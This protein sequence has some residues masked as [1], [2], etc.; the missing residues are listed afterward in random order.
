MRV[1]MR[2][3]AIALILFAAALSASA[4]F[5]SQEG[6]E[7]T[8]SITGHVTI[9]GKGMQ[10]VIVMLTRNDANAMRTMAGVFGQKSTVKA[11]TDE[12]G[13]YQ[14]SNIAAGRYSINP[15]APIFVI[16]S[17]PGA[18]W[19]PGKIVNIA[20]GETIEKMDFA[21]TRGGVITGRITDAQGR[22]VVGQIVT[23]TPAE[24]ANKKPQS[25]DPFM[26]TALGN[27]MYKTDDRGIYRIY[28]L[29]AGSYLVSVSPS[30][31]GG[32]QLNLKRSYH[33]Q[34]FHPGVTDKTKASIVEV[35]EGNEA[36][37]IDIKLG[38]PAQTYKASGRIVDAVT[39]KPIA[40]AVANYGVA[41]GEAKIVMPRGLGTLANSKGEFQINQI[42]QG[43][44]HAFVSFDEGSDSYSDSTPFEISNGDV[45]GIVIK[46]HRGLSVSGIVSIEGTTD[47]STLASLTQIQLNGYI[48]GPDAVAPKDITA[49]IAADGTFRM[50]GL[51]PGTLH[52]YI[53]RF[54]VPTKLAVVRLERGGIRQPASGLQINPGESPADVRIVLADANAVLRGQIRVA[55]EGSLEDASLE[56]AL[57]RAGNEG[58]FPNDTAEID[59]AGRFVF[60]NLLPDQYEIR[61]NVA[62]S[63]GPG[64]EKTTLLKQTVSVTN[65]VEANV[66]LTVDLGDK[67]DKKQ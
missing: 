52:I 41:T 33:A 1:L 39:G 44:Y 37:G 60:E 34:T 28:G 51:R 13:R 40:N 36:N 14:F 63:P 17:E 27:P 42:A 12:E 35:K 45:T 54:F 20:D 8:G 6:K 16:P 7:P 58:Q 32:V 67:K 57:Y 47:P 21:L 18:G 31:T 55:G 38:L 23:L 11:T 26:G 9:G 19:P 43:R 64:K 25:A 66:T 46:A 53:N 15:F 59:A 29:S 49:R 5:Q 4:R 30:N 2:A 22:P 56:V 61:V 3:A 50:T 62:T 10:G 48:T 24:D 65:E